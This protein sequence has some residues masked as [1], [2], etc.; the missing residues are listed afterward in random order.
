VKI[1]ADIYFVVDSS[2][3]SGPLQVQLLTAFILQIIMTYELSPLYLQIIF[4]YQDKNRKTKSFLFNDNNKLIDY[5]RQMLE[6]EQEIGKSMMNF[7]SLLKE[8]ETLIRTNTHARGGQTPKVL[9]LLGSATPPEK[10][11]IAM[12]ENMKAIY[13]LRIRVRTDPNKI[14]IMR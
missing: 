10:E 9:T 13:A 1:Q 4:I 3:Q 14:Y 7:V 12:R 5:S 6:A 8:I 11:R 2:T